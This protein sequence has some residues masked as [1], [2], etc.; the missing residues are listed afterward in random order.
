MGFAS[1][2]D[3]GD[4]A[5]VAAVAEHDAVVPRDRRKPSDRPGSSAF[6]DYFTM[7]WTLRMITK[8]VAPAGYTGCNERLMAR[9]RGTGWGV[10]AMTF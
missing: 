1:V 3:A 6:I 4:L 7:A 8:D 10:M 2:A 9:A 5:V